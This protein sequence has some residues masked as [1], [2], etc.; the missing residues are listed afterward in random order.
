M[1]ESESENAQS[2]EVEN[3][4]E[5]I[6]K[7][8]SKHELTLLYLPPKRNQQ[9]RRKKR[10][11]PTDLVPETVPLNDIRRTYP[12][13]FSSLTTRATVEEIRSQFGKIVADDE[14]FSFVV[15]TEEEENPFGPVYRENKGLEASIK[16]LSAYFLAIP[17]C[18]FTYTSLQFY[19]RKNGE[20][21]LKTEFMITGCMAFK[22]LVENVEKTDDF[23][24]AVEGLQGLQSA[25]SEIRNDQDHQG[26]SE[27]DSND[28]FED[29]DEVESPQNKRRRVDTESAK[30][31]YCDNST[32]VS[33]SSTAS[34]KKK[35]VNVG[36]TEVM[37]DEHDD[38]CTYKSMIIT[39]DASNYKLGHRLEGR[40]FST[41]G[42]MIFYMNKDKKL[43]KL[44][45][46]YSVTKTLESSKYDSLAELTSGKD[47]T[48]PESPTTL[49]FTAID[50]ESIDDEEDWESSDN[51]NAPAI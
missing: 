21:V 39:S 2:D 7:Q 49:T 5:T 8:L 1:I 38:E 51:E 48:K 31:D 26:Y 17:D 18:I 29:E 9:R 35:K 37:I 24:G 34:I 30:I 22:V 11:G 40:S 47:K 14:D 12:T 50:N 42:K 13:I 32:S 16:F 46:Q 15:R 33:L 44:D 23:K 6:P 27:D 45:A 19:K 41:S 36:D 3:S 43:I 4:E 10:F 28:V 20:S 25:S